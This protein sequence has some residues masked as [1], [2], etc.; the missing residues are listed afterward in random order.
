MRLTQALKR[1]VRRHTAYSNKP[2][3]AFNTIDNKTINRGLYLED[4]KH[5]EI[6]SFR[7][8]YIYDIENDT[9]EQVK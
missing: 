7:A 1:R 2:Y 9:F 5:K 4:D 8:D 6:T 3:Y